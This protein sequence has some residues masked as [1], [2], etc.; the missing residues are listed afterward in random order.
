MLLKNDPFILT[1]IVDGV[2]QS[3]NRDAWN[4][5]DKNKI[6]YEKMQVSST[7]GRYGFFRVSNC[8]TAK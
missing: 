1:T 4:E 8:K 6:H 7:L 5:D 3:K 2:E